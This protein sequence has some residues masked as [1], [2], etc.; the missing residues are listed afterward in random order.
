MH[1]NLLFNGCSFTYGG[2]LWGINR[3]YEHQKLHRFSHLVA[4]EFGMSYDNI[5]SGGKSND[6]IVEQTVNWFEAGNTC[7]LAIIQFTEKKRIMLY[8]DNKN[9]IHIV[10]QILKNNQVISKILPRSLNYELTANI[11]FKNIYSEYF[12]QQNFYK[13]LFFI[14]NYLK[15]KN[16]PTIYLHLNKKSIINAIDDGWKIYCKDIKINHIVEGILPRRE[17]NKNKIYYCPDYSFKS[18]KDPFFT[19][20]NGT[21]PN[22][23]G[24]QKIAEYIIQ[25]IKSQNIF[26]A[27]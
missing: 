25:E 27:L 22:E 24:H 1:Y 26:N 4:K 20:M 16:I 21:H 15:S 17:D 19:W 10:N 2:E 5:S 18:E 8:D 6:W 14:H 9:P 3:D 11:Y 12:G 23:L 7:D 13:N